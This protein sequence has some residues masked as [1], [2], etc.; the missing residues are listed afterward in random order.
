MKSIREILKVYNSSFISATK[1]NFKGINGKDVYNITAPFEFEKS[2]YIL[3]RVEPRNDELNT[4]THFFKKEN[5]SW[6]KEENLPS[7]NLQDPFISKIKNQIIL[8]GIQVE[9]RPTKKDL[10]YRTVFYKGTSLKNLKPFTTGPWGMKGIRLIEL[11]DGKIGVFTRPQGRKGGL[12]RI[13]FT[14]I[15]T[16]NSLSPRVLSQAPLVNKYFAKGEWGGVNEV[17]LLKNGY[18]GVLAHIARFSKDK[19][20]RFYYPIAFSFNPITCLTSTTRILVR[21]AELPEGEAKRPDLYNVIYPGGLIRN[22][23]EGIANLYSGVGDAEAYRIK[24]K[25]PFT[26]YENQE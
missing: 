4:E 13:G 11:P 17:H 22:S 3:G 23:K 18:L 7:F 14:I 21:R 9:K 24:I 2:K 5:S 6:I 20:L 19:Q 1:L 12:G 15:H 26:F 10:S 8:G 25:D 16:L